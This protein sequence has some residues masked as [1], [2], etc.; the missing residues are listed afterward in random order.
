MK[1]VDE[2]RAEL[3]KRC[4]QK[5]QAQVAAELEISAAY[6]SDILNGHRGISDTIAEKLDYVRAYTKKKN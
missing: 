6:L 5:T 1:S 4:E 2:L 3:R